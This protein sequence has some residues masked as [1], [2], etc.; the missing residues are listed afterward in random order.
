MGQFYL[1]SNSPLLVGCGLMRRASP[2]NGGRQK[3]P[4]KPGRF[5]QIYTYTNK[6]Q[7]SGAAFYPIPLFYAYEVSGLDDLFAFRV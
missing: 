6:K 7:L 3:M 5:R 2:A 4:T 1:L